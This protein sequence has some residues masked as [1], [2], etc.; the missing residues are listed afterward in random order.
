MLWRS[1]TPNYLNTHGDIQKGKYGTCFHFCDKNKASFSRYVNFTISPNTKLLIKLSALYR[2]RISKFLETS[3]FLKA[4]KRV[5]FLVRCMAYRICFISLDFV[6]S[7]EVKEWAIRRT[8]DDQNMYISISWVCMQSRSKYPFFHF[9]LLWFSISSESE[10]NVFF[11]C[12]VS[13]SGNFAVS[14]ELGMLD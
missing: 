9:Q 12:Y 14:W 2:I 6:S 11:A 5:R 10:I 7:S 13:L 4:F 1:P 8:Q 3:R